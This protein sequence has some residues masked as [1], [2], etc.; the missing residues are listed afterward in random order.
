MV[1][2]P[3]VLFGLVGA[4]AA[5]FHIPLLVYL[6]LLL[7]DSAGD[8]LRFGHI[9][10]ANRHFFFDDRLLLN[11][12]LFLTDRDANLLIIADVRRGGLPASGCA[13]RGKSSVDWLVDSQVQ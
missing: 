4:V 1:V 2:D 6:D 8:L 5:Y 11:M 9:T 7:A 3:G 13:R 10:L 12:Y